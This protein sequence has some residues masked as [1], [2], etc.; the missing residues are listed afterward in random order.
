[1]ITRITRIYIIA[2]AQLCMLSI[3][4]TLFISHC[5]VKKLMK[6]LPNHDNEKFN[7]QVCR[8]FIL[9]EHI[10]I[11]IIAIDSKWSLVDR[12]PLYNKE[13]YEAGTLI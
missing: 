8:S 4:L 1:M 2:Q 6:L 12:K 10:L 9:T 3:P 5:D 11:Q 13:G 7:H